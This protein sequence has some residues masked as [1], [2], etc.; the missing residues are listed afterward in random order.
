[1]EQYIMSD[2][3][4][5]FSPAASLAALGAYLH[6]IDL[7]GPVRASVK[8]AQ[9]TVKYSPCDKLYDA[10][11]SILAGAHGLIEI[12]TRLRSDPA[13][14]AALGRTACAQ[15]AVVQE[16]LNACSAD[17]VSQLDAAL[18]SIYRQ[19]SQGYA[20]N[21]TQAW[22]LLDV[23]LTGMPCGKKAACAC[24]GYFPQQRYRRGRQL[25]RVVAT[26]YHEIVVDQLF[27]GTTYLRTALRPLLEA[28][29]QVLAL[30]AAKRARTIVRIDAGGGSVGEINWLLAR[31]YQVHAKDYSG[32][33]AQK[34]AQSV[35]RWVDDP[36]IEG[37]QVGWV[38][39]ATNAYVRPVRRIAVRCRKKNGQW[40]IGVLISTLVPTEVLAVTDA[41]A[42]AMQDAD[43]VLLA[44]VSFYDQRGGGVE[45]AIKDDKQGLGITKRNKKRFAAQQMV[46]LL[47]VLAHNVLV[48]ARR[49]LAPVLPQIQRYG[50]M[51]LVRDVWQ[52]SGFVERDG[53]G[54][55]TRIVLNQFAPLARELGL[56]LRG[57]LAPM[58]VVV[59][60]GQT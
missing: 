24:K 39:V 34:L 33:R 48:W 44:Y 4:R 58:P 6:H 51:R 57:L 56:A 29:E 32:Q 35:T 30:D 14:Q 15:Q 53:H 2:P 49:W 21:Y 54:H 19:P 25:G 9:K 45:T 52:I 40:G 1:M 28:A 12:N 18:R 8:I 20:H 46:M 11:I 59:N 31:G 37:R 38:T 55:L 16:T 22:Q 47:N 7:F 17:Q 5:H 42:A 13:L 26:R 23:D 3:A 43:A 27:T 41:P 60:W 50:L 10:F 36:H